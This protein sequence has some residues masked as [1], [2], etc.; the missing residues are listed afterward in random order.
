PSRSRGRTDLR[1]ASVTG[2]ACLLLLFSPSGVNES[3]RFVL[4]RARLLLGALS[5]RVS[6]NPTAL[7]DL[8]HR[9]LAPGFDFSDAKAERSELF[10]V[11]SAVLSRNL[12][13]ELASLLL[14]FF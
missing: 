11:L 7:D 6:T 14:A 8:A 9:F 4:N 2:S 13:Q 10:A 1:L 5:G 12:L 3:F